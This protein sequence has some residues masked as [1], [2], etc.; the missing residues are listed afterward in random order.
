MFG[1]IGDGV[2]ELIIAEHVGEFQ[3]LGVMPIRAGEEIV[4]LSD[5]ENASL[6]GR[7]G[8]DR[9]SESGSQQEDST[10]F[11]RKQIDVQS[12]DADEKFAPGQAKTSGVNDEKSQP[13]RSAERHRRD[14]FIAR[15]HPPINPKPHRGG[16]SNAR[17]GG[18]HCIW[19]GRGF[20]RSYGAWFILDSCSINM[21]LLWSSISMTLLWSFW[22]RRGQRVP[23]S[24]IGATCL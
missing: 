19:I 8:R 10:G 23:A 6:L 7:R 11:S 13:A 21:A 22:L 1:K 24:A 17:M 5:R 3:S 14:M 4:F 9:R 18:A 2:G 12:T 15:Q 20:C 16:T